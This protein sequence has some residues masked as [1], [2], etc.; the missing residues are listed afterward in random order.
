[1]SNMIVNVTIRDGNGDILNTKTGLT[2]IN[3]F[4]NITFTVGDWEYDTEIWVNFF[5]EDNFGI[6]A[7]Y[8]VAISQ[9]QIFRQP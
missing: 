2:D 3:G 7:R 4:F 8:Y 5:P 9:Q 6:P 1:M